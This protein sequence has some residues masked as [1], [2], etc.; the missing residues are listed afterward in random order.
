MSIAEISKGNVVDQ[1]IFTVW[2]TDCFTF[3]TAAEIHDYR[4]LSDNLNIFFTVV[5]AHNSFFVNAG[6]T[7]TFKHNMT[8]FQLFGV[9]I[10]N[11]IHDNTVLE[12]DFYVRRY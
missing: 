3:I 2:H 9:R 1:C 8:G 6:R 11:L 10:A 5:L 4:T 7:Y 12:Q